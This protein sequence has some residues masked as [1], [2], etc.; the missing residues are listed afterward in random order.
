MGGF[1]F[2][3]EAVLFVVRKA[4]VKLRAW[5]I[6]F[7]W[8]YVLIVKVNR[9]YFFLLLRLLSASLVTLDTP[10]LTN[11]ICERNLEGVIKKPKPCPGCVYIGD[12]SFCY[13]ESNTVNLV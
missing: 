7:S 1:K 5:K 2:V 10:Q 4:T 3:E 11:P 12:A 8:V 9:I 6:V 13:V